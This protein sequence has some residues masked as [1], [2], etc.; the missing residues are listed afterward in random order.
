MN[1]EE[2]KLNMQAIRGGDRDAFEELFRGMQTP[3]FTVIFRI[4]W[5]KPTSEEILQEVFVRLFLTPLEP[6]IKNPRAYIFQM[7]RNLA[8]DGLR[9]KQTKHVS[10]YEYEAEDAVSQPMDDIAMRMDIDEALKKL[11]P[12]EC[13]IVT[14]HIVGE[15]KFREISE[16]LQVPLGTVLWKYQKAISKLQK[17]ITGGPR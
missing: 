6:S 2:L 4:T 15:L 12:Q 1:N 11:P 3:I 8:I 5:D 16:V 13:Q 10:I 9:R 17:M 14:L 7:A